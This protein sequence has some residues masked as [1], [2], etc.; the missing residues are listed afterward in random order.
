MDLHKKGTGATGFP[1]AVRDAKLSQKGDKFVMS[2]GPM[3]A[4]KIKDRKDIKMLS[5]VHSSTYVD[6]AKRNH[7]GVAICR[8]E[9]VHMYNQFMGAVDHSDQ[10]VAYPSF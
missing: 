10:M 8:C 2:N 5:T 3:M 1:P 7:R 4:M 9:A 6:T